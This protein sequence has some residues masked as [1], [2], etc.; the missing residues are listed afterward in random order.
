[1]IRKIMIAGALCLFANLSW[2]QAQLKINLNKKEDTSVSPIV[3]E[4]IED[5]ARQINSIIQDEKAKM[6]AELADVVSRAEKNGDSKQDISAQKAK[7]ADAY[8]EKI[9]KRIN[10]LGFSVDEVIQKQVKYS[11][12]NTD[13]ANPEEFKKKMIKKF[14]AENSFTPY[15]SYGIMAITN[16]AAKN[17][18]DHN[19]AYSN[20]LEFGF[21]YNL[22][23]GMKS[24]WALVSGIGLS[25]RTLRLDNDT[26]FAK[27]AGNQVY[28]A[29]SATNL[30]KSK[31][32]TGYIMVPLGLQYNFSS[33]KSAGE[34][35]QY[36]TY[37]K[38]FK[39]GAG[40]YGGAR[41][42][43]NNIIKGEDGKHRQRGDFDVS[44]FVYGA[45]LTLSYNKTSI[46]VKQDFN[47]FFKD[48]TFK[49][50]KMIQFGILFDL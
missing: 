18:L 22:Q 14:K 48:Q 17:D 46:F 31:L 34:D 9:D 6:E 13:A 40:V 49:N 19:K 5:Y 26:Y 3:K 47:N 42:S 24:P 25:W 28:V 1:M 27:D 38:G 41:M 8:S 20:N 29:Q 43:S 15:V 33:L 39:I 11:L 7:I 4:K 2:A 32:R 36:R 37:F 45:Q 50:N 16:D 44:N 12:L 35:V 21:K 23:F 30:D 10:D